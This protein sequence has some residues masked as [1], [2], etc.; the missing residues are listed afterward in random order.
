MTLATLKSS[1]LAALTS[2]VG[3]FMFFQPLFK[4]KTCSE[5]VATQINS[6]LI[7]TNYVQLLL[8]TFI[9]NFFW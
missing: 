5:Q 7:R 6:L 2:K 8:Q 4:M 1:S 3:G 9:F